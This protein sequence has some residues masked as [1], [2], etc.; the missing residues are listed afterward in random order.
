VLAVTLVI[1]QQLI[2]KMMT[3]SLYSCLRQYT[4]EINKN[5][6]KVRKKGIP[7]KRKRK[8]KKKRKRWKRKKNRKMKVLI[9]EGLLADR[10]CRIKIVREE[11]KVLKEATWLALQEEF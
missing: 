10:V 6:K 4:S 5:P 8:E 11:H 2:Q 3:K 7:N 9:K 1:P